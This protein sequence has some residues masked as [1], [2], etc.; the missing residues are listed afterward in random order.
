[1]QIIQFEDKGLAIYSYLIISESDR[2][3]IVIDPARDPQP[4]LD[5]LQEYGADLIGIIETHP[6]ADFISS[7]M[8]LCRKTGAPILVSTKLGAH[9]A[10]QAFDE[11]QRI[12]TAE[13]TLEAL[14]TPGHSPDGLTVLLR[15][16][17][18]PHA[19]F[20]GDTLF[21]GDVGRPDL[22]ESAGNLTGAREQLAR[23]M[24]QSTRQKLMTLPDNV[25]VYPGHGAGSLCG[26]ALSSANSST[27]GAEKMSN[28]ALAAMTENEF[29][30]MLLEDLPFAPRYF[31]NSVEINRNGAP[32]F[33]R[34]I[35]NVRVLLTLKNVLVGTLVIDTRPED[36]FKRAHLAGSL[37]L[38][39]GD[40]FETWLG[41][42]VN[43]GEP[44]VLITENAERAHHAMKRAAFIGYESQIAGVYFGE[45]EETV[46][47]EPL[48]ID[49]F[50]SNPD[51]YTI[52]DVRN[53]GEM[54][55]K[56]IFPG[57][58]HIPLPELRERIKEVPIGKPVVVHCAGGYRSPVA[59]SLL[60]DKLPGTAVY[61]L[62]THVTRF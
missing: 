46:A 54:R 12:E 33:A 3:G 27:I 32:D 14:H 40:K 41:S 29:V 43:P 2:K 49:D 10:F 24:Y 58:V 15:V 16:G 28:P 17:T 42:V 51:A 48:P 4:Y 61:D 13:F 55:T 60:E 53:Y 21:I 5:R 20:T 26:K 31:A 11:G 1:M 18:S 19:V 7:H 30:T 37:N 23:Q 9:Y 62:G 56:S 47:S 44:F 6:H 8:E 57:A 22:R 34:S 38:Q 36:Q 35:D 59:A 39:I 52:V 25:L 45:L 50:S